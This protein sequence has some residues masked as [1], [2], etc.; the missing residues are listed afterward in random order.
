[1][2]E[3]VPTP[4]SISAERGEKI[5]RKTCTILFT[6]NKQETHKSR[7]DPEPSISPHMESNLTMMGLEVTEVKKTAPTVY[8][9]ETV[10]TAI[11]YPELEGIH[12]DH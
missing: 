2:P 10:F 11:E 1:M 12:K 7:C 5:I 8:T 3:G 4:Y 6:Y 9:G